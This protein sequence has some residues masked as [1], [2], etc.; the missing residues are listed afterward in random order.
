M[1]AWKIQYKVA[2]T[3]CQFIILILSLILFITLNCEC[4]R[5]CLTELHIM[6]TAIFY[7]FLRFVY[8]A[9]IDGELYR[10][11]SLNN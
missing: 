1:R 5:Y 10:Y 7:C 11:Y 6:L 8:L 3:A 9:F 2:R 4:G